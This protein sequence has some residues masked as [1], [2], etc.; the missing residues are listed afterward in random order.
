M[1]IRRYGTTQESGESLTDVKATV[2]ARF[3]PEPIR[4]D[5]ILFQESSKG[6]ATPLSCCAVK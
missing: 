5:T 4:Y 6:H 1:E 3:A 2:I